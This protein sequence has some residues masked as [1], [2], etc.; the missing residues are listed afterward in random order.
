MAAA[1]FQLVH[2]NRLEVSPLTSW[3]AAR[4]ENLWRPSRLVGIRALTWVG[5]FS[6]AAILGC[7][8]G[9]DTVRAES[10]DRPKKEPT[11]HTTPNPLVFFLE[12]FPSKDQTA[13]LSV[14][15]EGRG[16]KGSLSV[17]SMDLPAVLPLAANFFKIRVPESLPGGIF[18][19]SFLT[20]SVDEQER[21]RAIMC[22]RDGETV[23]D[24]V[25]N[26]RGDM[27][28]A[29]VT[30]RAGSRVEFSVD[31]KERTLEVKT[32]EKK[33][34]EWVKRS[35]KRAFDE[36]PFDARLLFCMRKEV[37]RLNRLVAEANRLLKAWAET[38]AG[39]EHLRRNPLV[40]PD[41]GRDKD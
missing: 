39:R 22:Q 31:W 26:E 13:V 37:E 8:S 25:F 41:A 29:W 23:N 32:S 7:R 35:A 17:L 3:R 19:G 9:Q 21:C 6:S 16:K 27:V 30:D 20:V 10:A 4:G 33:D 34:G 5:L 1:R 12:D 28:S 14:W 2:Q 38:P 15:G 40:F 11:I 36:R 18:P 24:I